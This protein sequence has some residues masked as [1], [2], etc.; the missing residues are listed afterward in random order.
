MNTTVVIIT[1]FMIAPR[2]DPQ[3]ITTDPIENVTVFHAPPGMNAVII[4]IMMSFTNDCI[5]A[6]AAIPMMNAI[7]K[8]T[9]LYSLRKSMNSDMKPMLTN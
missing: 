1:K 6:V 3:L 2:N 5:N 7:A 4:G 9:T 8:A